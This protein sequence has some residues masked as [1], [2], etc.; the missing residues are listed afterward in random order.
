MLKVETFILN[1]KYHSEKNQRYIHSENFPFN[2]YKQSSLY[3]YI[4]IYEGCKL[5]FEGS[6]ERCPEYWFIILQIMQQTLEVGM[7][8]WEF[9]TLLRLEAVDPGTVRLTQNETAY[10]FPR[11]ALF[12][13]LL[14]ECKQLMDTM[15]SDTEYPAGAMESFYQQVDA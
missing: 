5:V 6:L 7:S 3:C 1:P 15:G 10:L 4:E 14:D 2:E 11:N 9:P 12:K 8:E 13:A